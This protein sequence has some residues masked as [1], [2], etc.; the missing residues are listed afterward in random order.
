VSNRNSLKD[1]IKKPSATQAFLNTYDVEPKK[2][3]VKNQEIT[4]E[5]KEAEPEVKTKDTSLVDDK[6]IKSDVAEVLAN[7]NNTVNSSLDEDDEYLR[8]LAA[9]KK[10]KQGKKQSRTVTFYLDEDLAV[11]ID[12][13]A[14]RGD[15]GVKTKLFN[16]AVRKLLQE[17]GVLEKN[18]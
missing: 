12:K 9:G 1:R 15:R 7:N 4:P 18:N 8:T 6:N 13:I 5:N 16:T 14:A 10:P 11:E 2:E 3:E 17:Y